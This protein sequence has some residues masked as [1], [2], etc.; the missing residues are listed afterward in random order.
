[1]LADGKAD[2]IAPGKAALANRDWR[3][4][5]AN[6]QPMDEFDFSVPQPLARIKPGEL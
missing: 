4:R 3:R 6:R 2:I 5:A 1:M